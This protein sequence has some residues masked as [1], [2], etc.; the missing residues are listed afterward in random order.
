MQ[1]LVAAGS[2]DDLI[3]APACTRAG[4]AVGRCQPGEHRLAERH[5]PDGR[6]IL[7]GGAGMC[8][9]GPYGRQGFPRRFDRQRDLIDEAGRQRD[10]IGACQGLGHQA[11]D[12]F[13]AACPMCPAAQAALWIECHS[14]SSGTLRR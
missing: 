9:V 8:R 2:D 14:Q 10:D 13:V 6:A 3:D 11:A 5:V 1:E 12:Q 4:R 7:Q